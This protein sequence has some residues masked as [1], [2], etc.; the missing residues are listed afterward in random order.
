LEIG[1]AH[2]GFLFK[3]K[4]EGVSKCVGI[5]VSQGTCDFAKEKFGVDVRLGNFPDTEIYDTFDVVCAFDVLEHLK[6]PVKALL[7]MKE[8]GRYV[9]VQVPIK[10]LNSNRGFVAVAHQFMFTMKA[11]GILFDLVGLSIV[12]CVD[13]FFK[14]DVLFVGEEYEN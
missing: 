12:R 9:A 11:V 10:Q 3:C 2:G 6:N 1:C 7:K 5:E 14:G 8:L 4:N 13:G